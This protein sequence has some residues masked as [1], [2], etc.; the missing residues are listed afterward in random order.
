M[1]PEGAVDAR[2]CSTAHHSNPLNHHSSTILL[3]NRKH[4]MHS[5]LS[6]QNTDAYQLPDQ[7]YHRAMGGHRRSGGSPAG[8]ISSCGSVDSVLVEHFP[9]SESN[10]S[11]SAEGP[12]SS[13][14]D[15]EPPVS[16]SVRANTCAAY[17]QLTVRIGKVFG[18]LAFQACG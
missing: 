10:S 14:S 5:R 2:G 9:D 11:P 17:I 15:L 7:R 1:I 8:S 4:C 18:K 3:P 16:E 13:S 6:S 12:P